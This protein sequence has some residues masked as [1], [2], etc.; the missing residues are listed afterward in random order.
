MKAF[1]LT[2]LVLLT[3]CAHTGVPPAFGFH[4]LV[5]PNRAVYCII[6]ADFTS[7]MCGDVAVAA[8]K[9]NAA[10]GWPLLN[11]P[12]EISFADTVLF[13]DKSEVIL[14]GV[15]KLGTRILGE[16]RVQL[17]ETGDGFVRAELII[18]SPLIWKDPM[19]NPGMLESVVLHELTHAVGA[20]HAEQHGPFNSVMK[21]A[22]A[23]GAPTELT[24][25]DLA[26]LRSA[27]P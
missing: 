8:R 9:I 7:D 21:P 14:V 18:Y 26:A 1:L 6:D 17:Y 2:A 3:G 23:P 10:V 16:T 12:L 22:W 24:R 20:G 4:G 11:V 27:Y 15:D 13:T 19:A 5:R 25:N